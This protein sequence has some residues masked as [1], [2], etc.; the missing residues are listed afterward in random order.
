MKLSDIV[1]EHGFIPS[2]L[3]QIDQAKLYERHNADGILELLCIQ[4]IG[5]AMRVDRQPLLAMAIH[6]NHSSIIFHPIGEGIKNFIVPNE[7]LEDYLN[8]TL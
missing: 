4:K 7:N 2:K 1:G 8:T 6:H 3:G 5:D